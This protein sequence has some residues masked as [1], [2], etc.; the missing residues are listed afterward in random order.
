MKKM[1][2][3]HKPIIKKDVYK[4]LNESIDS[5]WLTTGPQVKEFEEKLKLIVNSKYVIALNSCTA[6]L[7]LALLAKN[8]KKNE[9]FIAPTYTF[10]A[11]VEV[12]QYLNLDPVLIDSDIE[13]FNLDL[14]HVEY[15]LKKDK[16]NSIKAIIPVHFAGLAVDMKEVNYLAEKYNLFVLEDAAHALETKSNFSKTGNSNDA[17]AFSFYAN[18]NITTGGEGGAIATNDKQLAE[19]IRQ[20]SLHGMNKDGWKRYSSHGKWAYDISE[21]GCKYNMTDISASFGLEQ[22]IN[23][24]VWIKKRLSIVKKYNNSFKTIDGI[25]L[26]YN[27]EDANHGRHLYIIR[28]LP[29]LWRIPRDILIE[30]INSRGIGTSVHYIPIHLHSYYKNK[31]NYNPKDFINAYNL[32]KSVITIP[33]YPALTDNDV[34]YIINNI[35]DLWEKYKV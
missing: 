34:N 25:V 19:K 23:L 35:N 10:V 14:N 8:F 27:I 13:T 1:I 29:K 5:G 2:P 21:L 30:K 17:V 31:Y 18:K 9:K 20:L 3:F 15:E 16:N 28:I 4:I 11:T 32:S 33:L 26:P 12:G 22:L 6:A 24:D 7:H